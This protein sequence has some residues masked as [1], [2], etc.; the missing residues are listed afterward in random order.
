MTAQA[1]TTQHVLNIDDLPSIIDGRFVGITFEQMDYLNE[2]I[3]R[4]SRTGEIATLYKS[5]MMLCYREVELRDQY[6]SALESYNKELKETN[7]EAYTVIAQL[8]S[9][10]K[11]ANKQA[12]HEK[13]KRVWSQALAIAGIGSM[14]VLLVTN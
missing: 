13:N 3:I 6:I 14:V 12:K 5:N 8:R 10:L 2:M 9:D 7:A 1:D 4:Y 11:K